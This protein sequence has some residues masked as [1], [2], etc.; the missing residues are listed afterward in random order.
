V[1]WDAIDQCCRAGLPCYSKTWGSGQGGEEI[2]LAGR[3]SDDVLQALVG[4]VFLSHLHEREAELI[5][6][7]CDPGGVLHRRPDPKLDVFGIARLGVVNDG[8]GTDNQILNL[9][10]CENA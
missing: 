6:G 8:I 5:E 1:D 2:D 10:F 3:N 4:K 9:R 7:A